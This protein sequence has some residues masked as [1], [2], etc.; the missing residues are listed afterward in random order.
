MRLDEDTV[1][2]FKNLAEK[3]PSVSEPH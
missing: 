1:G 3:K 2:Y